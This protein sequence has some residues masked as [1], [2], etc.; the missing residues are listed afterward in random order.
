MLTTDVVSAALVIAAISLQAGTLDRAATRQAL[1]SGAVAAVSNTSPARIA[2]VVL[3]ADRHVAW[4]LLVLAAVLFIAD[5]VYASPREQ[6]ERLGR[7]H[8]FTRVVAHSE[9]SGAV[10]ATILAKTQ[11]H[12]RAGR[13]ELTLFPHG[14]GPLRIVLY[15]DG[16]PKTGPATDASAAL[17]ALKRVVATEQAILL[18]PPI[19]D[20][21]PRRGAARAGHHRRH[22]RTAAGRSRG[23]PGPCWWPTAS[24]TSAPSVTRISLCSRS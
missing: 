24:T 10:A 15:R 3:A 19:T 22:D 23:W 13:A 11:E 4:L 18:S 8:Q 14:R 6:D 5:R 2:V 1:A 12:L 21:A 20:H 16:H 17:E 9:R 7:L